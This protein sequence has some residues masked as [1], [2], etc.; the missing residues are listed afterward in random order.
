[1]T[2]PDD[3]PAYWKWTHNQ[4]SKVVDWIR[5]HWA[6]Y[7]INGFSDTAKYEAISQSLDPKDFWYGR[8]PWHKVQSCVKGYLK[9][10]YDLWKQKYTN[11]EGGVLEGEERVRLEGKSLHELQTL[12]V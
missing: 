6:E 11:P 3:E 7:E 9:K 4:R 12:T 10:N 5:D 2:T 8:P 1:M